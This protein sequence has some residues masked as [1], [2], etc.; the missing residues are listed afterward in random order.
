ME[1]LNALFE[2]NLINW[3]LLV[4]FLVYLWMKFMPGIFKDREDRITTALRE[5]EQARLE[6]RKFQEEQQTRIANAEKEAENILVEAKQM[7]ERMKTEMSVEMRKDA[8]S[9]QKKIDQQ[10]ATERQMAITELRSQAA[11]V[12]IRLAEASLPGAITP[13]VK[14][15]LQDQFIKQLDSIGN[16]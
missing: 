13:N 11:T 6:G 2:S 12:A 7:A 10:I 16:N 5:A 9:L 15:G 1:S 8:D 3:L 14:N 4:A